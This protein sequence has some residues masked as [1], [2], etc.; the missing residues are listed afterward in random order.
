MNADR[1]AER[2]GDP[3]SARAHSGKIARL[4]LSHSSRDSREAVALRAWLI[5]AEPGLAGEIFLDLDQDTGIPAGVRW[6]DALRRAGDRCEA[7]ICLLSDNW[8]SS[9]ECKVEYRH[10]ESM[11]K[12][13]FTVRLEPLTGRDMTSEWQRCDLFGEGP[14]TAISVDGETV[15]FL[16]EGLQRLRYGLRAAGIGAD[17]FAWPPPGDPGRAPYRGWEP[18][19]S[20]DAAVYF[21]RDAQIGRAMDAV[22]GL[23]SLGGGHLFVVLGPSGVGKSSFV[24][25]GLLPRLARDD[26]HF[27]TMDIV[28]PHR[29]ALTGDAGFARSIHALR[30][31]VGLRRPGLTEIED[32]VRDIEQVRAWLIEAQQAARER[33]LDSDDDPVPTLILPIDQAEELFGPEAGEQAGVLL[34][35]LG[36]LLDRERGI[37]MIAVATIRSDRYEPLQTAPMLASVAV[38]PF[39]DLKPMP[40]AQFKEVIVGPVRRASEAGAELSFAPDLVE[41]LLDDWSRGADTLPLLSLTL[42]RLYQDYGD[43]E[44]TLAHYEALGG[45]RRVVQ[46]EVDELLDDDPEVRAGQLAILRRAFVPWLATI[47]SGNDQPMRR[48][49][50]WFDLPPESHPLLEA[51]VA[52]RLLVKDERDG[53]VVVEV[54]LESLLRQWDTLADWLRVEAA[55]LEAADNLERAA[56]AWE[57]NGRREEWLLA[58]SRLT[59]AESLAAAPGFRERLNPMRS[60]LLD[61]RRAEDQRIEEE[62]R[63]QEDELRAA[64]ERQLAAE[65]LAATESRA[66]EDAQRSARALHRRSRI[67]R[68]ALVLTMVAALVAGLLWVR[69]DRAQEKA[70]AENRHATVMAL[71]AHSHRML[72]GKWPGKSNDILGMQM[73]IAAH[74]FDAGARQ[75]FALLEAIYQQGK[76]RKIV[77][78]NGAEVA[79]VAYSP[80][81]KLI[82]AAKGSEI[83]LLDAATWKPIGDPMSGHKSEVAR[84]AFSPDGAR[85]VSAGRDRTVRLWDTGSQKQIGAE[86]LGHTGAVVGVA[87]SPDG[88]HIASAGWDKTVRLWNADTQQQI[89]EM[90]GHTMPVTAVAFGGGG[91]IASGDFG[92]SVRLWDAQSGLLSGEPL[93]AYTHSAVNS[94]AFDWNGDRLVV[95][96][97]DLQQW[98]PRTHQPIGEPMRGHTAAVEQ[99]TYSRDSSEIAS[100]SD[101]KSI[102]LWDAKT[103]RSL[104]EP[105]EGHELIVS[106]IAFHPDSGRVLSGSYDSTV[107]EWDVR[108]GRVIH[109]GDKV[110][111]A[112]VSPTGRQ[113][114][115]G[116]VDGT[117][118][119]WDTE[120]G[121][122]IGPSIRGEHGIPLPEYAA[123]GTQVESVGFSK[124]S[125]TLTDI[126][127]WDAVSG[128]AIGPPIT[129]PPETTNV[130]HDSGRRRMVTTS[131]GHT[132]IR[133]MTS[134][135][136]IGL[137]LRHDDGSVLAISIDNNGSHIATGA[138]DYSVR[139]WDANTGQS[140]GQP[141]AGQAWVKSTAFSPDSRLLAVG[142]EDKSVRIWD[143]DTSQQIGEPLWQDG[144]SSQIRFSPDGRTIVTV[145]T[146]NVLRL[147]DVETHNQIGPPL[148]GHG[149]PITAVDF[150]SD[151]SRIMSASVDETIRIWPVPT[152]SPE[153]L[154]AKLTHN[155]SREMW[156]SWVSSEIDYV[157]LCEGLPIAGEEE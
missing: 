73:V 5:E 144:P 11:N 101:D 147:W 80:D 91:L 143:T 93:T 110:S 41:R 30:V 137:E 155:M 31:G 97:F 54:A 56:Q 131:D 47:N 6:K 104:G 48:P 102:R 111:S 106:S 116:G 95:A 125:L 68:V 156:R 114:V 128:V 75:E 127:F 133:D 151:G 157:V 51:F 43:G 121:A 120:T 89:S 64:R 33:V 69:A 130:V 74:R 45:L 113:I 65:T 71:S 88:R 132:Q 9:H 16:T 55:D 92:G 142:Y 62:R 34:T 118:R 1:S 3:R 57:Q 86:M 145:G 149:A 60:L 108:E 99:V 98:D 29:R 94:L 44:I 123:E 140:V 23:R 8:D 112:D 115:S 84:I 107:R 35:L 83:E 76:L 109:P 134:M 24:R 53:A 28:R 154:C 49:A 26:R 72:S 150:T 52:R 78:M 146:D 58:G 63:H 153:Q 42:A 82:A 22:R 129:L 27:L 81:G 67:L 2:G 105:L 90:T 70:V 15:E 138:S 21:G 12:P 124:E 7:V 152:A 122:Q 14:K 13:I 66:K 87:F 20:V 77:S 19:E 85:L 103:G 40:Q 79:S 25:A 17:T 61:S 141:M 4:F 126:R 100:A 139:L 119:Q 50:R 135:R 117:I 32:G 96:G 36:G 59:D 136:P 46:R 38:R 10:A 39:D 18:L 37:A 148:V